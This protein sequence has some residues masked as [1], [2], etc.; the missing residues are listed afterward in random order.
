MSHLIAS[1][2]INQSAYKFDKIFC[3]EA[4][5]IDLAKNLKLGT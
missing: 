4:T 5:Q 1:S 3:N 2:C